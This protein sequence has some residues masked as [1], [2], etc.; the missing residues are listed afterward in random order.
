MG[1][2]P[3]ID[4]FGVG[5][6]PFYKYIYIY[7]Y[8]YKYEVGGGTRAE[9]PG[10]SWNTS[11]GGK[12]GKVT[13]KVKIWPRNRKSGPFPTFLSG[14]SGIPILNWKNLP[15]WSPKSKN[16]QKKWPKSTL[17]EKNCKK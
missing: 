9:G 17:F 13:R 4:L 14:F 7:I 8:I 1:G 2:D 3:K 5:G 12:S 16:G 10:P 11:T 15:N 6:T